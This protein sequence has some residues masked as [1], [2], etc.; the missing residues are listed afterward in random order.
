MSEDLS[1]T[2][3]N[4]QLN[5][6]LHIMARLRDPQ[7]GCPWD[8]KQDFKSL[9]PYTIE[10]SYEVAE[11]IEH[12]NMDEVKGELGDLLFQVVFYSQLGKEQ[13]CFD[14]EQVAKAI[15][16]KMIHR[17]PH[18]FANHQYEDQEAFEKDWQNRKEQ[19]KQT[20]QSPL[21]AVSLM[22]DIS[23]TLPA[24]TRAIKIQKR[25][26]QIGFDWDT[27][28]QVVDKIKEELAEL[29]EAMADAKAANNDKHLEARIEDELGDLLC[30]CVNLSRKLKLDPEAVLRKNNQK[31]IRRFRL[32]EQE[33]KNDRDKMSAASLEELEL[34]WQIAKQKST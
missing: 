33:F 11:A 1:N 3:P 17:H 24:M 16:D 21:K 30:S 22:D 2:D 23:Q 13:N 27:T 25:A 15:S 20:K 7:T 12:G 19:E 26:T 29:E 6:L 28:A 9:V 31:F 8:L 4:A 32:I 5:R 10:E 34:A 14:F 18:V